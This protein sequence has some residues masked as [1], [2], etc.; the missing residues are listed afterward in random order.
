MQLNSPLI[1]DDFLSAEELEAERIHAFS[2]E[3]EDWPGPDGEVYKRICRVHREHVQR[4]IESIMGPVDMHGMAYRLNFAGELPNAAIHS[5]LGWG[6]HALVLYLQGTQTGTAFWRHR[7]TG[8]T[9]IHEGD[10][11][12][13]EQVRGDWDNIEAW[14]QTAMVNA[15]SGRAVIYASA[16]FHSR[17]P[18]AAAGSGRDDGRLVLVAFFTPNAL[19]R[20]SVCIASESDKPDVLRMGREFYESTAYAQV[21]PWCEESCSTLV[22]QLLISGLLI[23]ARYRE[24]AVGMVGLYLAPFLFSHSKRAAH[25]VFWWVDSDWRGVNLGAQLLDAVETEC[26][27]RGVDMIQMLTLSNSPPH[28]AAA[29]RRAGY[30]QSETC[31]TKILG[32]TD[33]PGQG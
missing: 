29:Y 9:Q 33:A 8:A 30:Q 18:F 14:E 23:V 3:F 20:A 22:D 26:R 28:A 17:F 1:V 7:A 19:R 27:S 32:R 31:F 24:R 21:S 5:D 25:E 11:A 4:K 12:L 15:L 16:A 13:F 2:S 10:E 6:T